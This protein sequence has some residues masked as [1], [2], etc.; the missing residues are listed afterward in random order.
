MPAAPRLSVPRSITR[1]IR[2]ASPGNSAGSSALPAMNVQSRVTA[3]AA[4][5]SCAITT[6]PLSSTARTGESP[7]DKVV[8][9]PSG[10]GGTSRRSA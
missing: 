5:V 7:L 6:A 3:G 8:M 2:Y 9:T 1:A 10:R 4:E